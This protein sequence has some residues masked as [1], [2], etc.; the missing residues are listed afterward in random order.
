MYN[1]FIQ[2]FFTDIGVKS[3]TG[4]ENYFNRIKYA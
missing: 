2:V 4:K 3:N 1:F